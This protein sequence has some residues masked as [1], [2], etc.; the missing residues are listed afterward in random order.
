MTRRAALV[1]LLVACPLVAAGSET[2]APVAG[3][4]VFS[5]EAWA[6]VLTSSGLAALVTLTGLEIVLG[7]DNIVFISVLTARLPEAKR[8][9][10]RRWGLV[11][12]MV[13]R[14]LLLLAVGWLMQLTQPLFQV[15]IVNSDD[16]ISGKDLILVAGGAFLL[17]KATKEIHER[18]EGKAQG[19]ASTREIGGNMASV[20]AQIMVV[21]LV[22]S[23]DSVITAVGMT[24]NIPVMVLAVVSS[25][26]VMMIAANPIADF[27]E[28]HP[29]M[30]VLALAFLVLIGVLLVAEGLG[31]HLEKGYVYFA[32]AFSLSVELLQLRMTAQQRSAAGDQ[33]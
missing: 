33:G 29:S 20:L 9:R 23:L 15:P 26:S 21:D 31:Q 28:R 4:G 13:S 22:F 19:D 10:V 1:V 27:V 18:V 3:G 11:A 30:K 7:I 24:A 25:V 12:A 16:G 32:M 8:P 6:A 5:A 17:F 2:S 14:I